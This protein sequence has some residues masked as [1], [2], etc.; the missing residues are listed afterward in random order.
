MNGRGDCSLGDFALV[1]GVVAVT[2][3]A[4]LVLVIY[5]TLHKTEFI[6]EG[7]S[8]GYRATTPNTGSH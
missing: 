6:H 2:F 3:I 4:V 8:Y 5:E 1:A 7:V